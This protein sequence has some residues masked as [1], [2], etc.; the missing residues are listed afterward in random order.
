VIDRVDA[1]LLSRDLATILDL[2]RDLE[3]ANAA[4]CPLR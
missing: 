4:S 1:A 3:L 2:A